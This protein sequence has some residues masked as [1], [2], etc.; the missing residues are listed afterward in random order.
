MTS[1]SLWP[2]DEYEFRCRGTSQTGRYCR[3]KVGSA[4]WN[5]DEA[6]LE[7]EGLRSYGPYEMDDRLIRFECPIHG[8]VVAYTNELGTNKV[9]GAYREN[10]G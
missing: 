10:G 5:K 9:H 2:L 4:R 6:T 3:K 1:S 7:F 8:E